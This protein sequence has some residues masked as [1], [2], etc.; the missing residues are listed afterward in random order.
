[1]LGLQLIAWF[2]SGLVMAI[3]P[4]EEVRGQHLKKALPIAD[5][6][7]VVLSPQQVL[8]SF[9]HYQSLQLG[10]RGN[11]PVYLLATAQASYTI[12]ARTGDILAPLTAEEI[13][14]LA[15][16]QYQGGSALQTPELLQHIPNEIRGLT[17][18]LWRVGV[19][20]P[21][22]TTLYLDATTGQIQRVRT[23]TWRLYDFFWMLHIMDYQHRENFNHWLLIVSAASALLFS[24]SG[25]VLLGA[26]LK[27]KFR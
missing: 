23:D 6:R 8:Q 2:A 19:A 15:A 20:D 22:H 4:I 9:P 26:A 11:E 7:H 3:L 17:P 25:M 12:S 5:W 27:R 13:S 14:E 1:M 18:P 10:Q 21:S 24:L 16:I